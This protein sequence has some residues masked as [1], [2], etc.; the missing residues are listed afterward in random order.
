MGGMVERG[1]RISDPRVMRA[2]SHPARIEIVEYLNDTGKAVTATECAEIVGLSPSATSYHLR[3]LAKYGLVE[4]AP[5]R[6]DGRE[7]LWQSVSPTLRIDPADGEPAAQQ[8]A[9]ALADLYLTR[10]LERVR[11]WFARMDEE[12]EEWRRIGSIHGSRLLV[13]AEELE[14]LAAKVSELIDPYRI[15]GRQENAP[16]GARRVAFNL[17]MF[18]ED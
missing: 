17:A 4:Q 9:A 15:R 12:P 14:G 1:V 11:E 5:S 8:A 13:T 7:R 3:E 18:P 10:D 2:L 6:G 16:E